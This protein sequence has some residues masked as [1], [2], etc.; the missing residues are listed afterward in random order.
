MCNWCTWD[1]LKLGLIHVALVNVLHCNSLSDH[2]C[3]TNT[4]FIVYNVVFRNLSG[5]F[6]PW[7]ALLGSAPIRIAISFDNST[8]I[9]N[10]VST[11]LYLPN[12]A[13]TY[14]YLQ[15]T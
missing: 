14:I 4:K 8:K 12:K 13:I 10:I 5:F 9:D 3:N 11:T 2:M 7:E 6:S 15:I 1:N